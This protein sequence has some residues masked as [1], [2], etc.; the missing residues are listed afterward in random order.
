M[1]SPRDSLPPASFYFQ[2]ISQHS[3]IQ[4]S[5]GGKVFK[6]MSLWGTLHIQAI[7][8]ANVMNFYCPLK[9]ISYCH[10]SSPPHTKSPAALVTSPKEE[11]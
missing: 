9:L 5:V 10:S 3:N 11:I 8:I 7:V 2:N 4:L 6:H 1:S